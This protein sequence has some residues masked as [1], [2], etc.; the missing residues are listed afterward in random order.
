MEK[1]GTVTKK[2]GNIAEILIKRDSACGENCAACGLCKNN[3]LRIKLAVS[4]EI[5]EGDKVRLLSED[6][7]VVGFSAVGYLGLTAFLILGGFLGTFL[8]GE[9]ASFLL[10]LV[11]VLGGALVIRKAVPK[12]A[13]IKVEKI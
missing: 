4:P 13:E 6:R 1:T 8:G 9:W 3:E 12:G 5:N 11:F 10:A 7:L 2:N